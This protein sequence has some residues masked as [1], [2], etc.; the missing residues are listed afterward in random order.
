[1]NIGRWNGGNYFDGQI[2]E[3][4][5]FNTALPQSRIQAQYDAA[6]NTTAANDIAAT[7]EETALP[8]L[9]LL[10]NDIGTGWSR[11]RQPMAS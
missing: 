2:D 9:N 5:I 4:A 3:V 6:F 7:N 8:S 1:M 10:G 11:P